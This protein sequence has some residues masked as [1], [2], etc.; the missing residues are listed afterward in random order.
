M[1]PRPS[2]NTS[3]LDTRSE[4]SGSGGIEALRVNLGTDGTLGLV[5]CGADTHTV[6]LS[7]GGMTFRVA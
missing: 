1:R 5:A 2:T 4:P 6:I 7:L 3:L